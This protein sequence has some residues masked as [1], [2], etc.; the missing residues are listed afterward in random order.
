MSRRRKLVAMLVFLDVLGTLAARARGYGV[1]G[2][3]LVRCARG[4]VFTTIWIPGV[5]VKALRLGWWRFQYCPV[6]RHWSLVR[7]VRAADLTRVERMRARGRRDVR[8]P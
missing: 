4:H 1:G 5:S 2:H 6:G 3:A 8:L 7:P